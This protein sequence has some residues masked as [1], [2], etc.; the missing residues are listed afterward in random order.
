MNWLSHRGDWR[1]SDPPSNERK[2]TQKPIEPWKILGSTYSF[3]DRWVRLRSDK[4]LLS[5]GT[6]LSPYHTLEIPD[7]VSVLAITEDREVI[8]IEQYRHPVGCT[9]RE[10][11]AGHIGEM[12]AP[13]IAAKR[14]L[15]EETGFAG[16]A[17]HA[18]GITFPMA[19][20]L[21]GRI[22]NFL[23]IDVGKASEPSPDEAEIIRTHRVDWSTFI[24]SFRSGNPMVREASQLATVL[25]ACQFIQAGVG[26]RVSRL[27]L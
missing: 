2:V 23:A 7:A 25:L 11:P 19:S 9:L 4:V 20:R 6:T 21:S 3:R 12:E 1:G 10:I 15:L 16:G 17:W 18:L 5:N 14:E 13:E 26:P 27:N 8:L 22:H 24:S